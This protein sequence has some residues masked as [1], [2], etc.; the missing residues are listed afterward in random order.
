MMIGLVMELTS[1]EL[2]IT[3]KEKEQSIKMLRGYLIFSNILII[4]ETIYVN[5]SSINKINTLLIIIMILLFIF[6]LILINTKYKKKNSIY[7][8]LYPILLSIVLVFSTGIKIILFFNIIYGVIIYLS[9]KGK[10]KNSKL[11]NKVENKS[12]IIGL[13]TISGPATLNI[14]TSINFTIIVLFFLVMLTEVANY[15]FYNHY[16]DW[17]NKQS[18][19]YK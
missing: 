5:I 11:N 2:E 19:N 9:I 13:I 7:V 8:F 6:R 10:F 17:I 1:K 18:I 3:K 16:E 15:V 4:L 14:D 12:L